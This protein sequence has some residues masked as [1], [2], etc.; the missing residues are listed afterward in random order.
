[1]SSVYDYSMKQM[2]NVKYFDN[3]E[4][5]IYELQKINAGIPKKLNRK[6]FL[7]EYGSVNNENEIGESMVW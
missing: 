5:L 3:P 7:F 6:N 1:M 2:K 4:E